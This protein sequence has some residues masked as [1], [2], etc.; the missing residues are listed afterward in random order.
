MI[1]R[2]LTRLR[3]NQRGATLIEFALV[4]PVLLMVIMGLLDMTY[5]MYAKAMLE[6]AVQKAARDSTLESGAS[7][8]ANNAIDGIVK[9]AFRQ[10]NGSVTDADFNFRRRNFSDFSGAGKMEPSTGPGGQCAAGFTYVDINNSNSWDDGAQDGQGGANDATLYT[11]RVTYRSLFPVNSLFGAPAVRTIRAST[12]L[13]N[14]PY[15]N[16]SARNTGPTRNC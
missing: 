11:V 6:G 12:V 14:Q 7:V 4:A 15:N 8:T 2:L 3:R 5:S 9:D 16:Q 13:R 1:R 10:A